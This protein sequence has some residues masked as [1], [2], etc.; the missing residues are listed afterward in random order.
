MARKIISAIEN[1]FVWFGMFLFFWL[2]HLSIKRSWRKDV[3]RII[4]RR[5]EACGALS[6]LPMH[7]DRSGQKQRLAAK[8]SQG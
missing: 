4:Q 2:A 7:V 5:L 1:A 6:P 8:P 3:D